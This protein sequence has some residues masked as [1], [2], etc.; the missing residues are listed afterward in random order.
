MRCM[1]NVCVTR[2]LHSYLAPRTAAASTAA[3]LLLTKPLAL[4]AIHRSYAKNHR[5]LTRNLNCLVCPPAR[6]PR[7]FKWSSRRIDAVG[8]EPA[9]VSPQLQAAVPP[10]ARV[11]AADGSAFL[12]YDP[13]GLTVRYTGRAHHAADVGTARAEVAWGPAIAAV[14]RLG[15]FEVDVLSPGAS[16]CASGR[17]GGGAAA[18]GGLTGCLDSI[19]SVIDAHSH[20]CCPPARAQ[21]HHRGAGAQGAPHERRGGLRRRG[22]LRLQAGR[23]PPAGGRRGRHGGGGRAD[24]RRLWRR[25][26]ARRGRHAGRLLGPRPRRRLLHPQ[27]RRAA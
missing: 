12:A 18:A 8:M 22:R 3:P 1:W 21:Q 17:G 24:R 13:D 10:P 5:Y 4:P 23:G 2:L 19:H 6:P 26:R 20:L 27:W 9:P 11:A 16:G 7:R 15:Y 25:R 14:G